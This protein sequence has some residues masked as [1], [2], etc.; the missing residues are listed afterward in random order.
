[1]NFR[2]TL[3]LR[4]PLSVE[5]TAFV[6]NLETFYLLFSFNLIIMLVA[7]LTAGLNSRMF[8]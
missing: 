8:Q 3:D 4:S 1:M 2:L 6:V 5:G 7:I